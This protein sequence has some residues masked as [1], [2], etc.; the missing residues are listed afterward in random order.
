M[1]KAH[2]LSSPITP[3]TVI[4]S[5]KFT[6]GRPFLANTDFWHKNGVRLHTFGPK[7]TTLPSTIG[8]MDQSVIAKHS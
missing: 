6:P 7:L 4:A 5:S 3:T 1:S 8:D 2:H